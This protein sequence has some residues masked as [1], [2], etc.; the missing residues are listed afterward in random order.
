[1]QSLNQH[2]FQI[3]LFEADFLSPLSPL[4]EEKQRIKD[5]HVSGSNSCIALISFL[6]LYSVCNQPPYLLLTTECEI[7]W[8]ILLYLMSC[9]IPAVIFHAIMKDNDCGLDILFLIATFF[10]VPFLTK[11]SEIDSKLLPANLQ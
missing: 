4:Q 8:R 10:S 6:H 1:M 11:V 3:I 9:I 5:T 2:Q 7:S